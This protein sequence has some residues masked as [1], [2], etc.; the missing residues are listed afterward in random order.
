MDKQNLELELQQL[1]LSQPTASLKQKCIT[2][3]RENAKVI[4]LSKWRIVAAAV[5]LIVASWSGYENFAIQ[6]HFQTSSVDQYALFRDFSVDSLPK[7]QHQF[8]FPSGESRTMKRNYS[9][10]SY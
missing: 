9:R 8:F 7:K 2:P 10:W 5:V 4:Y 3:P 1:R 6:S